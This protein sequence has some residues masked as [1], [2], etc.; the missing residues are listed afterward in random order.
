MDI[1]ELKELMKSLGVPF[2]TGLFS[3]SYN[4]IDIGIGNAGIREELIKYGIGCLHGSCL[5]YVRDQPVVLLGGLRLDGTEESLVVSFKNRSK[6]IGCWM[7]LIYFGDVISFYLRESKVYD[8]FNY[9]DRPVTGVFLI[10]STSDLEELSS[11]EFRGEIDKRFFPASVKDL[12]KRAEYVDRLSSLFCGRTYQ[13][14]MRQL[15]EHRDWRLTANKL[16]D[17]LA[18]VL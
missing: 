7:P 14:Q 13:F 5:V 17:Q 8:I 6:K 15:K 9:E 3:G 2:R 18:R 1:A 11:E 10:G 12:E 16:Y 4:S